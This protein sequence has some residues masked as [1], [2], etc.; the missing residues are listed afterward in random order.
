V[1]PARDQFKHVRSPLNS[2][3]DA[4][5]CIAAILVHH[6]G[7]GP[8][9]SMVTPI[10]DAPES[11]ESQLVH[12]SSQNLRSIGEK[13]SCKLVVDPPTL[14]TRHARASVPMSARV[15]RAATFV[16]HDLAIRVSVV[17]AYQHHGG[18]REGDDILPIP[19]TKRRQFLGENVAAGSVKLGHAGA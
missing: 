1:T 18:R 14:A 12:A 6:C 3:G 16:H 9:I 13:I 11:D 7:A 19:G 10:A 2:D 4:T 8:G 5:W 17:R 15:A